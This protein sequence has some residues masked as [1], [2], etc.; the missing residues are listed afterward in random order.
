M[1]TSLQ[2]FILRKH[3]EWLATPVS[4][5]QIAETHFQQR[6]LDVMLQKTY[7]FSI[8]LFSYCED[9]FAYAN[10]KL[11]CSKTIRYFF[12]QTYGIFIVEKIKNLTCKALHIFSFQL[13]LFCL[14]DF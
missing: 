5:E 10:M 8:L 4:F 7:S 14:T 9:L 3:L 11:K 12:M 6:K 2:N 13:I 1:C